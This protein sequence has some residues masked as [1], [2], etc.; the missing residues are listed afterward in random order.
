MWFHHSSTRRQI[1]QTR[2]ILSYLNQVT[3]NHYIVGQYRS[4]NEFQ[5][6][7]CM[8]VPQH[9]IMSGSPKSP[10]SRLFTQPF[11]FQGTDQRKHQSSASLAFVR[12]IQR[13]PANSPH[14]WPVTRK[15]FPFDDVIMKPCRITCLIA[16]LGK[17]TYGV[18]LKTYVD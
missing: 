12:R 9:V 18:H 5:K 11:Y 8:T 14:K 17:M 10:A 2:P 1:S 13:W 3:A 16:S 15:M 7:A 4:S 6:V